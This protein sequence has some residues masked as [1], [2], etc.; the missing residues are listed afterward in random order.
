MNKRDLILSLLDSDQTPEY[1]PAAF[2][3]H[4]DP[5]YHRGRAAIDKHLEFFRYTGMD[6]VKIQYEHHVSQPQ[7]SRPEDWARLPRFGEDFFA[8]PLKVVEG[9][10]N[11][12][13]DEALVLVTLYSPFMWASQ[14][15]GDQQL[16]RH[17]HENLALVQQGM[18]AITGSVRTFVRACIRLGVDGFYAST[19][20]GE[21]HRFAD[22]SLFNACVRPY[23]LSIMEEIDQA[24]IF[25]VLHVCDYHG[26]YDDLTRFLDYPGHVVNTPLQVGQQQLSPREVATLFNRPYMGGMERT[27]IIASGTP[28]EVRTTAESILREAPD[29]FILAADCTVPSNTPWDNLRTAIETAHHHRHPRC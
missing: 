28:E 24:C 18:E 5:A 9:L 20:G 23:D 15:A 22:V 1:V 21:S 17:V 16:T 12:A 8:E 27:G 2:F 10:V 13:K 14:I 6:F 26:G 29:R 11:A 3:L 19:Q 25:N 7:I 4:F